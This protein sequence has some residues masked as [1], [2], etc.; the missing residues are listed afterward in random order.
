LTQ[1]IRPALIATVL[2]LALLALAAPAGAATTFTVTKTTDSNDGVCDSDCSLREAI[3]AANADS[4]DTVVVPAGDYTLATTELTVSSSMTI[5]GSGSGVSVIHAPPNTRVLE[6]TGGTVTISGVTIT[7]GSVGGAEAT[8]AGIEKTGGALTLVNSAVTG[9]TANSNASGPRGGGID[10]PSGD[11]TITGSTISDNHLVSTSQ[12]TDGGGIFEGDAASAFTITGSRITGNTSENGSG[13]GIETGTGFQIS[14][15]TIDGN[16]ASSPGGLSLGGGMSA[17][18]TTIGTFNRVTLSNNT[19]TTSGLAGG[20]AIFTNGPLSLTNTTIVG[21]TAGGGGGATVGGGIQNNAAITL[22]NVT[23]DSNNATLHN[24]I[25]NND[26][27]TVVNS[28]IANGHGSSND[29]NCEVPVTS[30]GHNISSDNTCGFTASGDLENT[31]PKLGLL[32]DNGGPTFTELP[33]L[34]SPALNAG[35]AGSCPATDQRGVARPQDGACDIGAVERAFSADLA[36]SVT[37]AQPI[38]PLV[39]RL[40]Y[41]IKVT[42][43]GPDTATGVALTN[44]LPANSTVASAPTS[45]VASGATCALGSLVAGASA[46]V[47]LVVD[48]SKAGSFPLT[49]SVSGARPDP[50]TA[51]N[52]ATVTGFAGAAAL[53]KLSIKPHSFAAK[54]RGATFSVAKGARVRFRLSRASKVRFLVQQRK[55]VKHKL[56]WVTLKGGRSE[57]NGKAG[58]NSIRFSG[59]VH[60][61]P[62]APGRYRLSLI[63]HDAGGTARARNVGF[64]IVGAKR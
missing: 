57:R 51:N 33:A 43:A 29:S 22:T 18:G 17:G 31:D 58:T 23:M 60:H 24:N 62:L 52:T 63:A 26:S 4:G 13:A 19:A 46:T 38:V 48:P 64:R 21:N 20:G 47:T 15:T 40:T 11:L 61:K 55:R 53:S 39:G 49:T 3:T 35:L 16:V 7:G 54:P 25:Q 6:M 59:R 27:T 10:N 41:T 30:L 9:N 14:D 56:R 2:S 34:D 8:G 37:L 12:G 45:C 1:L 42:N 36:V 44:A 5:M 28:I 50:N 32:A